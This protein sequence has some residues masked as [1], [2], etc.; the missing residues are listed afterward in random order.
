M[1]KSNFN[2]GKRALCLKD[3]FV[4]H[5]QGDELFTY[6]NYN[7]EEYEIKLFNSFHAVLME[8]SCIFKYVSL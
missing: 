5:C 6:C 4:T 1:N 8:I 7:T 2:F 3:V